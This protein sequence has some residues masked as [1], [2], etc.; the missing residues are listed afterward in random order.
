M[1]SNFRVRRSPLLRA[2]LL[3]TVTPRF[4]HHTI[5]GGGGYQVFI[6]EVGIINVQSPQD[7]RLPS[8]SSSES[9]GACARKRME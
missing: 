1:R 7:T 8:K 5:G 4:I 3:N 2:A 9:Y 6:K